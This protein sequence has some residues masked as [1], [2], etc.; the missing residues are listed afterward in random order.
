MD[1]EGEMTAEITASQGGAVVEQ[2]SESQDLDEGS[3][4]FGLARIGVNILL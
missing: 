4:D 2:V 1:I 3:Y